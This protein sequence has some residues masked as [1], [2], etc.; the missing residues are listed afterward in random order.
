MD[1]YLPVILK[2]GK[3]FVENLGCPSSLERSIC[4]REKLIGYIDGSSHLVVQLLSGGVQKARVGDAHF[5]G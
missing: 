1:N 3:S 2:K 4:P 5:M